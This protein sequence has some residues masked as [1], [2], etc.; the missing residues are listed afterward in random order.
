MLQPLD[1]GVFGPFQ[2][3]WID[4]CDE[5]VADTGAEMAIRDF[6][7][8][9]MGVRNQTFKATTIISAFKKSGIRPL[10]PAAF[11]DQDYAPSIS[12]STEAHVP[13]SYPTPILPE[14]ID[15]DSS[16]DEDDDDEDDDEDYQSTSDTGSESEGD[17]MES[18]GDDGRHEQERYVETEGPHDTDEDERSS[19]GGNASTSQPRQ[20]IRRS[21]SPMPTASFYAESSRSTRSS[22]PR[23]LRQSSASTISHI[24]DTNAQLAEL[25]AEIK[26]IHTRNE[27]LE[28]HCAM[29][30]YEIR[31]LKRKMNS[32]ENQPKKKRKLN[33]E[34]RILTSDEGLALCEQREVESLAKEAKKED[35]AARKRE[36]EAERQRLRAERGPNFSG[37]LASKNKPDL[38]DIAEALGLAK[39]GNKPNLLARI[40]S[41]FD[42]NI[43]LKSEARYAGLFNRTR[44]IRRTRAADTDENAEP[45]P[46][47]LVPEGVPLRTAQHP[48]AYH[49]PPALHSAPPLRPNHILL[50]SFPPIAGP[51]SHHHPY[52]ANY[53]VSYSPGHVYN[54]MYLPN[55]IVDTASYN[56]PHL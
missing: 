16:N 8:E 55:P 25:R 11:T 54:Q 31:D 29:A 6:V 40:N 32:R 19:G 17:G 41:H 2:R 15:E 27:F 5:V 14:L 39:D 4:R 24:A 12:T 28:A 56:T 21:F 26:A 36:K 13:S 53:P 3:A 34:A 45:A 47:L 33:V 49:H 52:P 50:P 38:Q 46:S 9:Y 20:P 42:S 7:R 48:P 10:N 22:A 44:G 51:S 30:T 18:E 37:G 1:V 23:H 43:N 35:I